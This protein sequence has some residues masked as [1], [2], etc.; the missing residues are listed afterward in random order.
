MR[1]GLR[2][3]KGWRQTALDGLGE[4]DQVMAAGLGVAGAAI[5]VGF[6]VAAK[7]ELGKFAA[8][9]GPLKNDGLGP[10]VPDRGGDDDVLIDHDLGGIGGRRDDPDRSHLGKTALVAV[11]VGAAI[12]VGEANR[13]R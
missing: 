5:A 10:V 3:D 8:C 13:A 9:G 2:G 4:T 7:I 6:A 11:P 1:R 12:V